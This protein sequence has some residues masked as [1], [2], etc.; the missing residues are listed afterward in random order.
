MV[1]FI[2]SAICLFSFFNVTYV[3]D[4]EALQVNF[5]PI[6]LAVCGLVALERQYDFY[7]LGMVLAL[8]ADSYCAVRFKE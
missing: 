3:R 6:M 1:I 2:Y 7:L 8:L 5:T 4:F